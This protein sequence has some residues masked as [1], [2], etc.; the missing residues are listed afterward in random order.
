MSDTVTMTA[1]YTHFQHFPA[2]TDFE[3]EFIDKNAV[4]LSHPVVAMDVVVA[5]H[6]EREVWTLCL[7]RHSS[8]LSN[9]MK[10]K[11]QGEKCLRFMNLSIAFSIAY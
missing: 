8:V 6:R 1:F 3:R 2:H 9:L 7:D 10:Q 5:A 4:R 11:R